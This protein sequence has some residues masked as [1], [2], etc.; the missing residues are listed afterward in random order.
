MFFLRF[1]KAPTGCEVSSR[2]FLLHSEKSHVL[3][4]EY[5]NIFKFYVDNLVYYLRMPFF[6]KYYFQKLFKHKF[7]NDRIFCIFT[8]NCQHL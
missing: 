2:R 3:G 7:I 6:G 1:E 5:G 8:V 4:T